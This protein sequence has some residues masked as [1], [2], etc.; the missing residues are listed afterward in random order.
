MESKIQKYKDIKTQFDAVLYFL[1]Q[2]DIEM[3][4]T[5]LEENR[6]YQDFEKPFFISLLGAALDEFIQAG[7]TFLQRYPGFCNAKNCNYK[8]NGFTFIG[9]YSGNY[10]NLIFDIQEGVVQD[11]Y[12]CPTFKCLEPG[13]LRNNLVEIE[14][15]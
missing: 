4:D 5:L 8:C 1:Q 14:K 11:M 13:L 10:F 12:E 6:T 2:L 7:D 3:I 9:N 15:T